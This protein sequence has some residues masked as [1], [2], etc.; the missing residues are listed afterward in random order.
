MLQ[1]LFLQSLLIQSLGDTFFLRGAGVEV[2]FSKRDWLSAAAIRPVVHSAM[3][4]FRFSPKYGKARLAI[5]DTYFVEAA[6]NWIEVRGHWQGLDKTWKLRLGLW[7]GLLVWQISTD[8][9]GAVAVRLRWLRY[10]GEEAYGLGVQFV[11]GAL[12]GRRYRLWT[13]E[14]G[15]GRGKQPLSFFVNLFV[16][17]AA[18]TLTTT[19]APMATF[20]TTARRGAALGHEGMAYWES[21]SSYY[22]WEAWLLPEQTTLTGAFWSGKDWGELLH[23]QAS[24]VGPM[25]LLPSWCKGAWIGLQ[26]GWDRVLPLLDALRRAGVPIAALWIQDWCGRRITRFGSQL[27]WRWIPDTLK[28]P[29]LR[30][31]VD[32]LRQLG[33]RTLGYVNSFLATEGS[34]YDTARARGYLVRKASGEVYPI[35]TPGFPAVLVDLTHPEAYAWLGEILRNLWQEYGFSGWMADYAEWVPWDA[36]LHAGSGAQHHN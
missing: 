32:S 18:G 33:I 10:K 31:Y 21:R 8:S 9:V 29:Q 30:L 4:S 5:I 11:P 6:T 3:G 36:Q 15:I 16:P 34:L 28:Y 35:R 1:G 2:A 7:K 20:I 19:Y 22:Q 14:Q 24:L 13:E 23:K 26:G 12:N 25:P 27:W 17:R